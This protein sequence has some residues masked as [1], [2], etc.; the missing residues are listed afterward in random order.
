M[1]YLLNLFHTPFTTG[2]LLEP[3]E[4]G[5]DEKDFGEYKEKPAGDNQVRKHVIVYSQDNEIVAEF[6]SGREMARFFQI[7]GKVAR[8]AI[9]KAFPSFTE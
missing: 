5:L 6:K 1:L 8:A 7:D 4:G 2:P 9:A 3:T